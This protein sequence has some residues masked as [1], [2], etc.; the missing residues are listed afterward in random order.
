MSGNRID[1]SEEVKVFAKSGDLIGSAH[2]TGYAHRPRT[3]GLWSWNGR[4]TQTDF[5]VGA[6]MEAGEMRLE[7]SDGASGKVLY[8]N[9]QITANRLGNLSWVDVLGNGMPPRVGTN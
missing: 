2:F 7:F 6:V 1:Y 8:T 4:L 9:V 3:G 5:E